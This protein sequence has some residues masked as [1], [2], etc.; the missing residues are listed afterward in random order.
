MWVWAVTRRFFRPSLP[1]GFTG[2]FSS[3]VCMRC[4]SIVRLHS[5]I[6]YDS[7][8]LPSKSV[9]VMLFWYLSSLRLTLPLFTCFCR[10][11]NLLKRAFTRSSVPKA[12]GRGRQATTVNIKHVDEQTHTRVRDASSVIAGE[13]DTCLVDC[14]YS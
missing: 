3:R 4:A 13:I 11:L 12:P 9:S 5:P 6:I 8:A 10:I 2:D 14:K 7:S 1:D